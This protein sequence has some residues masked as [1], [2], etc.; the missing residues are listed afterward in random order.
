MVKNYTAPEMEII[1]LE[2]TDVITTSGDGFLSLF[3]SG[4]QSLSS[5]RGM[6]LTSYRIN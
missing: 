1:K 6:N 2:K 4:T 5:D 3:N